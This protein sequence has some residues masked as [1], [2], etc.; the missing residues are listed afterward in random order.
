[1]T[2]GSPGDALHG[3][4]KEDNEAERRTTPE[5]TVRVRSDDLEPYVGLRYVA[6]LFRILAVLL[7][8]LLLAELITGLRL[9]GAEAL[10]LLLAE[11]GRLMVLAGLLWGSADL[12]LLLI[13]LGHDVRATRILLAR[14][15]AHQAALSE[16][17]STPS[18]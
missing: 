3:R 1:M 2:H 8:V 10:V 9:H 15:T 7:A 5:S 18:E 6:K 17:Q 14:Y 13:D 12:A 11:G 4:A 16:E